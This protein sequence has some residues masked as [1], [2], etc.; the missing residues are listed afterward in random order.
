MAYRES[1]QPIT[2]YGA[3]NLASSMGVTGYLSQRIG[4]YL[5]YLFILIKV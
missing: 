5:F 1:G 3:S 4:F 2:S